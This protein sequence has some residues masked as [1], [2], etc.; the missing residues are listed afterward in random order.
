MGYGLRTSFSAIVS[1]LSRCCI[2]SYGSVILIN[3]LR[4]GD[5]DIVARMMPSCLAE[6]FL[7]R[8]EVAGAW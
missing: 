4:R 8:Q 6:K 1:S 5:V 2:I 3:A 7:C